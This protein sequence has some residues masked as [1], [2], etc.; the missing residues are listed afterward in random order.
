MPFELKYRVLSIALFLYLGTMA[1]Y[2]KVHY[3][4]PTYNQQSRIEFST[5]T[6]TTLEES[7]FDVFLTN[8]SGNYTRNLEGLSKENP[9]TITLPLGGNDGIF[10]GDEGKTNQVLNSEGFILTADNYFFSSQIHAVAN[11]AAVIAPKGIAGLGTEF[12]S[13]HIYSASGTNNSRAHFLSVIASEDH[14]TVTFNNPRVKWEGQENYQFSVALNRGESYVLAASFNYISGLVGDDLFNAFNGTHI[15]SDRPIAVNSGSFLASSSSG[16]QDAG[17]DQ[18]VPVNQ[19]NTEFILAQGQST[20][21]NL[22]TAM[23]IASED[24][25]LVFLN[26]EITPSHTLQKGENIVIKGDQYINQTMHI[27]T[28]KPA[29]VYQNLAS[30]NS[31]ANVGMVFV[32]GLMEDAS[33]SVLVSGANSIGSVSF[34]IIAKKDEELTING[35]PVSS[36]PIENLGNPNWVT[37]RISPEEI[38]LSYCHSGKTCA[39]KGQNTNFLIESSGPINAAISTVDGIVGAAGYFSG[40]AAV[41]TDVGVSEFGTLDFTIPCTRDTVSLVAKGADTYQWQSLTGDEDMITK[42]NDSTYL[43]DYDQSGRE[44]P[45]NFTIIMQTTTI[46]GAVKNDTSTVTVRV[47]LTPE[48]IPKVDT[49]YICKG[50]KIIIE[51]ENLTNGDWSGSEPFDILSKDSI[52]AS[53]S[54]NTTYYLT[55]YTKIENALV[56]GGFEEP[57]RN[58]FGIISDATVPGWSTTAEDRMMEF[59]NDGFLNTPAYL[60]DQFVELNAN[61]IAA[62]YQDMPTTPGDQL[63]WGFAHRGRNGEESMHFEIGPPGGPYERIETI[64]TGKSWKF[65]QGI[66]EIPEG[67]TTTRFYY[68]SAMSG[69]MGNLIDAVEFY[70]FKKQVD[71]VIVIVQSHDDITLGNDTAM[72]KGE[73]IT[74]KLPDN[75]QYLWSNGSISS[76]VTI[77]ETGEYSVRITHENGCISLDTIQI[78]VNDLPL[79]N[80]GKDTTICKGET[81]SL[82]AWNSGADFLWNTGANIQEIDVDSAGSYQVIVTSEQGCQDTG[83]INVNVNELPQVIL[84]PTQTICLGDSLTLDAKNEGLN[85]QWNTGESNQKITVTQ[86]GKYQVIVSD[87]LGCSDTSTTQLT[88]N[89]PPVVDIGD[90]QTICQGDTLTLDAQN[91]G[92]NFQWNNG[93]TD[94]TIHVS[95]NGQYEVVVSDNYGCVDS[96]SLHLTVVDRP[97]LSLTAEQSICQGDSLLLNAQNTG[98]TFLWNTE[99]STQEIYVKTAG[100]YKVIVTNEHGCSDSSS[101]V[102]TIKPIPTVSLGD[103]RIICEGESLLLDAQNEGL[104][105][106]WNTGETSQKINVDNPGNYQVIVFDEI[107]CT[108]TSTLN[109]SINQLPNVHLGDQ[110]IICGEETIVLD[111]GNDNHLYKWSNGLNTQQIEIN[112]SGTYR[113]EVMDSI[114]CKESGEINVL[115]EVIQDPYSEKELHVCEGTSIT[116]KPDFHGDYLIYWEE[117]LFSPTLEVY[118]TGNYSSIVE[119]E[120]CSETFQINVTKL[121]TPEAI[122][123]DARNQD[124]YCFDIENVTLEVIS[125]DSFY[126]SVWD[127]FGRGDK[128]EIEEAGTYALTVYN[129]YCSSRLQKTLH[130]HCKGIFYI[131]NAFTPENQDGIN[132]VFMPVANEQVE[133]FDFKIFNRWGTLLYSTNKQGEGWDGK[134]NGN[135]AQVDVYSY[136]LTYYYNS[137]FEGT[138]QKKRVGHFNL[139]R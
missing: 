111:A 3:L 18:I 42:I 124:L 68:S 60:G 117:D 76:E 127:D 80:L 40:F 71:S 89:Q 69:S 126:L 44:G 19:L 25:T 7:P 104:N 138:V 83:E 84:A 87:D 12:Y 49:L 41:N 17:V 73:E 26:G 88:V 20:N 128:V 97:Q 133:G 50:E 121:D 137:E 45:F 134:I 116:L 43:F 36:I 59:W 94:Q 82:N 57:Y 24:N 78:D 86:S 32:P 6:V 85:F 131:P 72:C 123:Q 101:V 31:S 39:N 122:I 107:G 13:G 27:K 9:I 22:E 100:E 109:L 34:Y 14:T 54:K 135:S 53:P 30:K 62:L 58:A 112:D 51:K 120:Y 93:K 21:R 95:S 28:S 2:S 67:Q 99:A 130:N 118:E 37:Y 55:Q 64:T 10:K 35:I 38:N 77:S 52:A 61:M 66:Y 47:E 136:T 5:I 129:E 103:D 115:K 63:M 79:I 4:P 56:N 90:D 105:F 70:T 8:A 114:G 65:Y 75:E 81:L 102:L 108:D 29:L 98:A 110:R 132:D 11:Q 92:L 15:T 16:G 91:K 33:R 119:G 74:F 46:L 48:C 1:Q 139:L 96:A 23:I 113:V 106:Q 125:K